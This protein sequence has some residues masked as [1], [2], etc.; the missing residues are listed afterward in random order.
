MEVWM[1]KMGS[2]TRLDICNT[3]YGKKKGHNQTNNLTPNHKKSG[4]D[5]IFVRADGVRHTVGKL[6]TRATT[7]L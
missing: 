7:F 5:P 2:L 6:S 1:S 3:N 4:I